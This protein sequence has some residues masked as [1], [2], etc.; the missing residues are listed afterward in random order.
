MVWGCFCPIQAFGVKTFVGRKIFEFK[1]KFS[2]FRRC[3]KVNSFW[4]KG[5]FFF[6]GCFFFWWTVS[7]WLSGPKWHKRSGLITVSDL[8]TNRDAMLAF[9]PVIHVGLAKSTAMMAFPPC[10]DGRN[11]NGVWIAAKVVSRRCSPRSFGA[12]KMLLTECDSLL[13]GTHVLDISRANIESIGIVYFFFWCTLDLSQYVAGEMLCLH[14][15]IKKRRMLQ[16]SW[17]DMLAAVQRG[18]V[19]AQRSISEV[20]KVKGTFKSGKMP[21]L[22]S[23]F[24]ILWFVARCSLVNSSKGPFCAAP[25]VKESLLMVLD[26]H[27]GRSMAW[28]VSYVS[29]DFESPFQ[30]SRP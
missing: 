5:Y 16:R 13:A 26:G 20:W 9:S 10:F 7:Q 1:Q 17:K 24:L 25:Q 30:R 15:T 12:W 11:W 19:V 8:G 27:S 2:L 28:R 18:M 14:V 23:F 22:G 6:G 3:Q 21:L 4:W 29:V